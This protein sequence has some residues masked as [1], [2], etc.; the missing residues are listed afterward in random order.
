MALSSQQKLIAAI[1]AATVIIFGGLVFA[2]LRLPSGGVNPGGKVSF[3]DVNAPTKGSTDARVIVR[4][5][6]DFQCP[7]CKASEPAL[8]AI[9]EEFKDRVKFVWKDFPLMTIHPNARVAANAARCAEAQGK[10]WEY[11]DHLYET[12]DGWAAERTPKDRF[13]Q[14]A[15]ELGLNEGDFIK[16][17]DDRQFDDKVMADV[18]E[19]EGNGVNAT[20]TFY[21]NDRQAQVRTEAQWRSVLNQIIREQASST[22][23]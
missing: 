18:S 17:Y 19:G 20:P 2:L 3:S 22:Q 13:I 15:R 12:Q 5:Y 21:V 1:I 9:I 11:H 7:A 6:S 8:R 4:M 16:C 14:F 10:F 23:P